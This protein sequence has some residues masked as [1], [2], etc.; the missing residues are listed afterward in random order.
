[1]SKNGAGYD[2][3]IEDVPTRFE[4]SVKEVGRQLYND[5]INYKILPIKDGGTLD[6]TVSDDICE[7]CGGEVVM[8]LC[9]GSDEV[10]YK[11]AEC[12]N[13]Y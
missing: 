3:A 9:Q 11:C 10:Y 4:E 12:G 8:K 5:I 6:I 7:D 13:T 1:M 2:P